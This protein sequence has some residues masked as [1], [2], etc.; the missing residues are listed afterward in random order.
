MMWIVTLYISSRYR[1]SSYVTLILPLSLPYQYPCP[2]SILPYPYH[3]LALSF[4]Y[5]YPVSLSC[6]YFIPFR[7]LFELLP[8]PCGT[9]FK[10][11]VRY[12][13][14]AGPEFSMGLLHA[15]LPRNIKP[16]LQLI[17]QV[18]SLRR[19]RRCEVYDTLVPR[20]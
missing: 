5:Q 3:I 17:I 15:V 19:V 20:L 1:F 9:Y 4:S 2:T 16:Q 8:F 11:V 10:S 7:V 6:P 18:T 14:V 12:A 13:S